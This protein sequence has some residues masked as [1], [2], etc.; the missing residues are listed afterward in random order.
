MSTKMTRFAVIAIAFAMAGTAW[1]ETDPAAETEAQWAAERAARAERQAR[2]E[3]LMAT[4]TEE[5]QA[6]RATSNRAERARLMGAHRDSMHEAMALMRDM[7]GEH[8]QAV[9]AEHLGRAPAAREPSTEAKHSHRRTP[10]S[11][12]RAGMS[13]ADRLAD[14]ETRLDMMQ[15]M[16]ESML[17]AQ[18]R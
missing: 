9:V 1:A 2:L 13:D 11:R 6:I 7:G 10:T 18:A 17:E 4:M 8:M 15:I 16:M 5:M 14:L 12:P 3:T